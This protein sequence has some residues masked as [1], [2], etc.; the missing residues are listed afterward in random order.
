MNEN[1]EYNGVR[2]Y[3]EDIPF[4]DDVVVAI[5][6]KEIVDA[7]LEQFE[8]GHTVSAFT[9]CEDGT[10]LLHVQRGERD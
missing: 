4:A 8:L 6:A 1:K 2:F 5:P 3:R 9:L 7:Y 10:M